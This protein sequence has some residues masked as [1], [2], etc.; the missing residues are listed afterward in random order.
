MYLE[1]IEY[2]EKQCVFYGSYYNGKTYQEY[3]LFSDSCSAEIG[4]VVCDVKSILY[5]VEI[6]ERNER[7]IGIVFY[8]R[9]LD[10]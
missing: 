3:Q 8:C 9:S 2:Q 7:T 1:K 5:G 10:F 4:W 6:K